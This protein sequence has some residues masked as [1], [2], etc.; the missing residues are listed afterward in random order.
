LHCPYL[1]RQDADSATGPYLLNTT[2]GQVPFRFTVTNNGEFWAS[3]SYQ[4]SC[5]TCLILA[6]RVH[7]EPWLPL[8]L[9][10]AGNVDLTNLQFIDSQTS[11]GA[12]SSLAA[13][14]VNATRTFEY[15]TAWAAGQRTNVVNVSAQWSSSG[16]S[17]V[18]NASDPANYFGSNPRINIVKVTISGTTAGDGIFAASGSAISWC[19]GAGFS[20]QT[21]RAG[22]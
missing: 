3:C 9:G 19:V 1:Q 2:T 11:L 7:C 8:P 4:R 21:T 13:L 14:A 20:F 10:P 6:L 18:V 16:S 17:G 15:T 5:L 22:C 12:N